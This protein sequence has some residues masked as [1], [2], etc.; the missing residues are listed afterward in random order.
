L[1]KRAHDG[2][3]LLSMCSGGH[4]GIRA[5]IVGRVIQE[6]FD[7]LH[8]QRIE[9]V[10][11]AFLVGEIEGPIERDPAG[12]VRLKRARIPDALQMHRADLDDCSLL[13]TLENTI[14]L[15]P[16]HTSNVQ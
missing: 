11:D 1:A 16:T 9:L 3:S 2:S 13:L 14:S 7:V 10:D 4:D 12:L 5:C 8:E 15:A 6:I